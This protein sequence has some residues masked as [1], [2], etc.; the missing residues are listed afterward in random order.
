MKVIT[1]VLDDQ[2]ELWD[3]DMGRTGDREGQILEKAELGR[4][5]N[6]EKQKCGEA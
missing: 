5:R 6:V 4:C 1:V 3:K 2:P